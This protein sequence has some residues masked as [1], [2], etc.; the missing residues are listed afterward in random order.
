MYLALPAAGTLAAG[1]LAV[2]VAFEVIGS[3]WIVLG[4][5]AVGVVSVWIRHR[6]QQ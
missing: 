5:A 4:P 1:A 6:H 2:L 3:A